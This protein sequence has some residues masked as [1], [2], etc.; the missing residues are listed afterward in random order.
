MII[1]GLTGP[2]GTGKTT[3]SVIAEKLGYSVID[4]DKVAARASEDRVLLEKLEAAFGGVTEKGK[5]NRKALAAKAFSSTEQTNLLNSIM[6]PHI[7]KTINEKIENL[8]KNG[9]THLIL[10]APTLYESGENEKCTAVIAVLADETLRK[11][12]ILK[13]DNLT[14]E[15]LESRLK[16]AKPDGFYL[17]KAEHIVYNNG[18][19]LPFKAEVTEILKKY[20]ER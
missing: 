3:V 5:L 4:C 19:I 1:L 10:D 14:K 11:N 17:E 2:S 6:L 9:V 13:R 16:A 12:R 18:D 20:K 8:E 7:V 15:Q